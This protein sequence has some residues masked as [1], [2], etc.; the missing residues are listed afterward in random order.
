MNVTRGMAILHDRVVVMIQPDSDAKEKHL[1]ICLT[2]FWQ[3]AEQ[4]FIPAT[5]DLNKTCSFC[6]RIVENRQN[7]CQGHLSPWVQKCPKDM[8]LPRCGLTMAR[9]ARAKKTQ[10]DPRAFGDLSIPLSAVRKLHRRFQ[11][12]DVGGLGWNSSTSYGVCLLLGAWGDVPGTDV[13]SWP[14]FVHVKIDSAAMVVW[15]SGIFDVR[16]M[17]WWKVLAWRWS[18]CLRGRW[19]MRW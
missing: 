8:S 14:E 19:L 4:S 1:E 15:V 9:I 10:R 3:G 2:P 17:K 6:Q 7:H 13:S 12:G 11:A 16:Q 5:L 18:C